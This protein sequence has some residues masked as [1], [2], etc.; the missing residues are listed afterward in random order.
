MDAI[1]KLAGIGIQ[2][3]RCLLDTGLIARLVEQ[4]EPHYTAMAACSEPG[5]GNE[6]ALP[7]GGRYIKSASSFSL[8]T[9]LDMPMINTLLAALAA[10]SILGPALCCDLDQAWGRRQYPAL[11]SP[12]G[13]QPHQWHQD[14][15][16]GFDFS[17]A[18]Q[19]NRARGLLP[20][21]TCWLPLTACGRDAPGLEF[22]DLAHDSVLPV[23]QL[24]DRSL[25]HRFPA[26]L[27]VGPLLQAGDVL[28]FGGGILHRTLLT[29]AM[30]LTRTSIELRF[31]GGPP[32]RLAAD[33]F[34]P[35]P[36]DTC[37]GKENDFSD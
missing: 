34:L 16:L 32:A 33:R 17:S 29:P 22:L 14:G 36:F 4:V 25:R 1:D 12:G 18:N 8:D 10:T 5:P 21:V 15:A 31:F 19:Q 7:G 3:H 37:R 27:F 6:V 26:E 2:H 23:A 13:H 24:D 11:M 9:V 28:L 35:L 20:L 30:H